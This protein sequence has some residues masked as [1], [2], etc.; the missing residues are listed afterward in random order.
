[1]AGFTLRGN[2]DNGIST[3]FPGRRRAFPNLLVPTGMFSNATRNR[4]LPVINRLNLARGP[5]AHCNFLPEEEAI[6]LKLAIR[7]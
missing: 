5:F 3:P 2:D 7:D 6:R 1:M 4:V